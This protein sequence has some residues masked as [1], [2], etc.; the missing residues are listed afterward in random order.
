MSNRAFICPQCPDRFA[1]D[2]EFRHHYISVHEG[3]G[4]SSSPEPAIRCRYCS[5]PFKDQ[6][7]L[8]QHLEKFKPC[9]RRQKKWIEQQLAIYRQ[10]TRRNVD[11][12]A[13][14]EWIE[15]EI[16]DQR[17]DT[18]DEAPASAAEMA[19]EGRGGQRGT[20]PNSE[21]DSLAQEVEHERDSDEETEPDFG[22]PAEQYPYSGDESLEGIVADGRSPSPL[23]RPPQPP[24]REMTDRYGHQYFIEDYHIPTVGEPI[25]WQTAEERA[26]SEY[27]DVGEL[28]KPDFFEI[29]Q[30]L[31]RSGVS[32]NFRN[33]I[34]RLNRLRSLMP[35]ETSRAMMRDVD[36]LPTGPGWSVQ[37]Y[38]IQGANGKT[39]IVEL[40]LRDILEVVKKLLNTRRFG[41]F[42][43]FKPI[44][45]WTSP[46]RTDRIRDE[47]PTGD[48]MWNIQAEI[49]DEYGTV[50]PIII[51]SDE[52]RLTTFSGDKKAHPVY[53]TIGNI[54][55]GLRRK[56][57]KRTNAL[58][59]Y[60]PVPKLDCEPDKE[61]RRFHR[62]DLFHKCMTAL[63]NP[64]VEAGKNGIEVLCADGGIRRIYPV[65]AAYI[66]DFPEQCRIGC[67]KQTFCP[68]CKVQPN[69]RGDINNAAPR[70]CKDI[71]DAIEDHRAGGSATFERLGL[72]EVDPFWKKLPHV[73][74]SCLLTPDLLHQMYKGVIKDHLT[75]WITHIL[76]KQT[77]DDRH[78]SMPEYHGM[79]HFKN[80][81]STVSQWTGRELKEMA[82]VLL[83]LTSDGD[84]RVV[85]AA[86]ALL[87]FLYLAHSSSLSDSE[88]AA[89]DTALRTFHDNK[90]VF[91]AKGAVTTK[92]G[93][94]GIPKLHMME[95]YT[96]LI[97]MLGTPDGFNTE[98]S[99]RL[100]IDFAKMG[101]RA[102][103]KV[104]ATKQMVVYIQRM[105]ALAMHEE[106]LADLAEGDD[107]DPP[108][109]EEEGIE[110][111]YWDEWFEGEEEE[112][113]PDEP[114]DSEVRAS[115]ADRLKE[116]SEPQGGVEVRNTW[117]LEQTDNPPVDQGSVFHPVPEILLAATPTTP[118]IRLS[119]LALNNAATRI[120]E[121]TNSYLRKITPRHL[122]RTYVEP[123]TKVSTW[124]RARLLHSPPPFK[125]SEGPHIDA[126]RAQPQKVDR[127]ERVSRPARFDT[128]LV[129]TGRAEHGIHR[130]RP[131]RVRAIFRLPRRLRH[132]TNDILVYVEMFNPTSHRPAF[133]I[134][135]F[136]AT[137]SIQDGIR[138]C[139]VMPLSSVRLTCHLVPRYRTL[140]PAIPLT[141]FSDMLQ[142]CE[143]FFV[144]LYASYFFFEL[145]QHWSQSG[146]E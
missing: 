87:D 19:D 93:F 129:A 11:Q 94:H 65:L 16:Y 111:E 43:E 142:I 140:D 2:D 68:L 44:K 132:V 118:S 23:P 41:R 57:S 46:E 24:L 70:T 80:G 47:L 36:K 91:I 78:A 114:I 1:T 73:D 105:E 50:V 96:Y 32:G 20:G 92:K 64:L 5:K 100:H 122:N 131:A 27:P 109:L 124:S 13:R 89:M 35:W 28:S 38:R 141:N 10:R 108:E 123:D 110:D 125:P 101:Y 54:P 128:V 144:N 59:G 90:G 126:V 113:E 130:Y 135:L 136:T 34:I 74:L 63:L 33:K 121:A 66:A 6:P 8:V 84:S 95:H 21:D 37:A 55:K 133:P 53:V 79:R 139:A 138:L 120:C 115:L 71:T 134:G 98:T 69:A 4:P 83:P 119:Q 88:R 40:W 103:N 14:E 26:Q 15:H 127:F 99:E 45:K 29:A 62:R 85:T 56:T 77:V 60:L 102:S 61:R 97:K 76:G 137:R 146:M 3:A 51:S 107:Y 17:G 48:W 39:E 22:L 7:A 12:D 30:V 31:L 42:L 86:R 82:K 116:F 104:N 106:H 25:R 52:T 72:Y 67:V 9:V 49:K 145:L 112:E 18:G 117:E 143:T 75:K 81:I 58:L